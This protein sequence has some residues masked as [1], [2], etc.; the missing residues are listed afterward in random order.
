M[1]HIL[2]KLLTKDKEKNVNIAIEKDIIYKVTMIQIAT[3]FSSETMGSEDNME[4][5]LHKVQEGNPV[6]WEFYI[7]RKYSSKIKTVLHKENWDSSLLKD[8]HCKKYKRKYFRLKRSNTRQ[9]I[10]PQE[11]TKS[12]RNSKY[13]GKNKEYLFLLSWFPLKTIDCCKIDTIL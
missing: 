11:R 3:D 9:K 7:Q 2:N 6:N 8:L 13:M 12:M 10:H 5:H 4:G 1:W